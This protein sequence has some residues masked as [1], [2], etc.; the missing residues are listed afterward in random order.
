MGKRPTFLHKGKVVRAA[1]IVFVHPKYGY[2]L[3]DEPSGFADIGGKTDP[4]DSDALD[5]AVRETLEETIDLFGLLPPTPRAPTSVPSTAASSFRAPLER[6]AGRG[7][8]R[9]SGLVVMRR[10][11]MQNPPERLYCPVSKYLLLLSRCP[12]VLLAAVP[13]PPPPTTS[14]ITT[15]ATTSAT[16]AA[17]ARTAGTSSRSARP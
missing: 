4:A 6:A 15:N 1:G 16:T 3:Q 7:K 13:P 8:R 11:L 14:P 12:K 5:T 17:A 9:C 2:L 10:W